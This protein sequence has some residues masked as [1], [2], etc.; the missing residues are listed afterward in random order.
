[1]DELDFAKIKIE[2][3]LEHTAEYVLYFI[4]STELKLGTALCTRD[5]GL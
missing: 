1:M 3:K 2:I 4:R 5:F